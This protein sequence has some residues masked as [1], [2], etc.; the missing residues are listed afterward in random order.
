[1]RQF[2]RPVATTD[3]YGLLAPVPGFTLTSEQLVD[4]GTT[5]EG[6]VHEGAGGGNVSPQ[7]SWSGAPEGTR[8]YIVTCF[9]PDAPTVCGFWHWILAGIPAG[10]TS[11]PAGAG[12]EGDTGLL[13]EGAFHLANDFDDHAY[14]GPMPPKGDRAHRYVF[15]VHALDAELDLDS[16][17][18]AAY[19][20]FTTG[21][22]TLA[23]ALLTVTHRR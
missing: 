7:L 22:H 15:A 17:D 2:D 11:L 6:Q 5:P 8:A 9:D 10:T 4:G 12:G 21:D 3:P 16:T 20:S 19:A 1:M 13:P 23:R 18:R 14:G